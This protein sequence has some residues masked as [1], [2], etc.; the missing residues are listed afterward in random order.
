M[1]LG[2]LAEADQVGVVQ[3]LQRAELV[4]EPEQVLAAEAAHGLERQPLPALS[5]L[6]LVD[7]AHAALAQAA[8]DPV[9]LRAA[10]LV[11]VREHR[12][13]GRSSGPTLVGSGV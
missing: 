12:H 3:V 11:R 7:H 8:D 2:E 6:D 10:E 13:R 4:L 1:L 5:I 9:A